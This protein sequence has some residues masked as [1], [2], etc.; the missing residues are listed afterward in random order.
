MIV[1]DA[2]RS[3]RSAAILAVVLGLLQLALVPNVGV[4]AGRANLALV[5]VACVC[6]GSDVQSAPVIGFLAG[7]FFDL[8]GSGPIGLMALLLTP[9]AY[10]LAAMGRPRVAD[11]LSGSCAVAIPAFAVCELAYAVVLLVTGQSSFVDAVFLRALPGAALDAV[12]F[13]VVGMVI[14]RAGA[15]RQGLGAGKAR[16]RKG[17]H[18][19]MK[20]L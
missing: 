2:S 5:F 10:G 17:S 12:A 13:A 14:S 11:D 7:L 6:L 3:R 9:L 15:Q 20:G 19:N 8:T 1:N 18:F 16:G 4:L